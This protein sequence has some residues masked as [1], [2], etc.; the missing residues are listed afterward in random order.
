MDSRLGHGTY[1]AGMMVGYSPTT[2]GIRGVAADYPDIRIV[3]CK[4]AQY[5]P[6]LPLV[7]N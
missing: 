4:A 5:E 1:M 3:T 6:A 2:T 7:P